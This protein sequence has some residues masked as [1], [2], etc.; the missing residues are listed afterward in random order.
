M[1]GEYLW[2]VLG[3]GSIGAILILVWAAMYAARLL[4]VPARVFALVAPLAILRVRTTLSYLK[5][6]KLLEMRFL[7][8]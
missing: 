1:H 8:G 6:K 7:Y 4:A 5:R 2:L 3:L